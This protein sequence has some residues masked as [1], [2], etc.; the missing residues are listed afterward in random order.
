M[1]CPLGAPVL[2]TPNAVADVDDPASLGITVVDPSTMV[3]EVVKGLDIA[4]STPSERRLS[5][6]DFDEV[7]LEFGH[8]VPEQDIETLPSFLDG[9]RGRN[10]DRERY[11]RG[12]IDTPTPEDQPAP[13]RPPLQLER[14][15]IS[16]LVPVYD[17]PLDALA[18][19]IDSVLQQSY[20][21]WE[22]FLVDDAGLDDL[23]G[24]LERASAEAARWRGSVDR[25]ATECDRRDSR[26]EELEGDLEAAYARIHIR[27]QPKCGC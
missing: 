26:A 5:R 2:A 10:L 12:R 13:P 1:S 6:D 4:L 7:M 17:P 21:R 9:R 22:L 3:H 15:L 8:V 16:I 11:L 20:E 24:Q 27:A 25:L 14:P 19:A 23:A 18:S